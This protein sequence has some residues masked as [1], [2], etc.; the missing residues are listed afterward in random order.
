MSLVTVAQFKA[1]AKKLEGDAAVEALYQTY[2]DAAEDVVS[3]Y[4][5]FS[6][7]S[8]AYT[9]T[10]YGDGFPYLNLK[11]KPITVLSSVSVNG[12]AQTV[13]DFTI[14][15]ETIVN[16]YGNA[17]PVGSVIVATYTAGYATV[18]ASIINAV[19]QIASLKSMEAGEN[20]GVSSASFD[21]GNT[22][23]FISY[24]NY[25]KYLQA[26]DNY[27]LLKLGRLTPW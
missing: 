7:A 8:A 11:S 12:V 5:G 21:G 20:I 9:H 14:D 23:S 17:F 24:T 3:T 27:R 10:L 16:K 26:I 2:I 1:Y 13:A 25:D 6:P 19:L 15:G 18:P 4:I 22:R